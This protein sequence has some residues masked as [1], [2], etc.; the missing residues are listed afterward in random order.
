MLG[1]VDAVLHVAG[2]F[3]ATSKSMAAACVRTATHYLDIMGEIDVFEALAARD[4]E[5]EAGIMLLPG[6]GFDVVPSPAARAKAHARA[7]RRATAMC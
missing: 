2:P 4:A 1:E 5:A 3:A 6:V 7:S